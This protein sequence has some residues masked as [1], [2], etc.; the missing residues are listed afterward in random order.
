MR[1]T[2]FVTVYLVLTR[3]W[4]NYQAPECSHMSFVDFMDALANIAVSLK[5]VRVHCAK[6]ILQ[7]QFRMTILLA[8]S[9]VVYRQKTQRR[10]Q[11][12]QGRRLAQ[13]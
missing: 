8:I 2:F 3:C 1:D 9:V 7:C 6:H 10:H 5:E 11:L 13:P 12:R 4:Y